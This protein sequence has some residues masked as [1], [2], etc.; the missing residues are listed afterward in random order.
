[1]K[2]EAGTGRNSDQPTTDDAPDA[3]IST[4]ALQGAASENYPTP[5]RAWYAT[6]VLLLVMA[7]SYVDR[8]IL[9]LLVIP[10]QADLRLSDSAMGFLLGPAFVCLYALIALPLGYLVD[11]YNRRNILAVGLVIWTAGTLVCAIARSFEALAI[12]R[13]L[14]GMGEACVVP[15]TFSIAAD[16]FPP[17]RR[18]RAIGAV[19]AG[20]S[21]GA[22]TALFGG[23]LLLRLASR[24]DDISWPLVGMLKPWQ[25]VF[26]GCGLPGLLVLA[27]LLTVAEPPRR[28]SD[29]A[30]TDQAPPALF[31][32][33]LRINAATIVTLLVAYVLFALIQYALTSWTP[34]MLTRRL[35]LPIADA[36]FIL[37]GV[38]IIVSP[39]AAMTGG[40]LGD[41]MSR[42]WP[43]GRVRMA[44]LVSPLFVPGTL[45]ASLAPTIGL[46]VL[47]LCLISLSGTIVG[48]SVYATMQELAPV[49]F[50]GR[51][52]ALYAIFSGLLGMMVGPPMVAL[53]TDHLFHDPASIHLSMLAVSLPGVLISIPL[54]ALGLRGFRSMRASA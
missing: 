32:A 10:I 46:V 30:V 29:G 23:G 34:T 38:T 25:L 6:I 44:L 17:H 35:A 33:F 53:L 3:G 19:S 7:L 16:H 24:I 8:T 14:V 22:G 18:G 21:I 11:R 28:R 13:A 4:Q 52:L 48:T 51:M 42:R 36:A 40:L 41:W 45:L 43:D 37:G 31:G 5:M 12:G 9:S 1:M 54:F 50:R 39:L 15:C 26:V 20:V 2:P 27:L 47:G 49:G